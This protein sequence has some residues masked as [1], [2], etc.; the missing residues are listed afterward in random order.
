MSV[1]KDEEETSNG[2]SRVSHLTSRPALFDL[3]VMVVYLELW[4]VNRTNEGSRKEHVWARA[5]LLRTRKVSV[6]LIN[7]PQVPA[8][9]SRLYAHISSTKPPERGTRQA[10][11]Q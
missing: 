3:M 9:V 5:Q 11:I 7:L 4:Q 10:E 8:M 1:N 2:L 6:T